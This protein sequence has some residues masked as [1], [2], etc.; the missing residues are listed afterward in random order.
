MA[1]VCVKA[2][3]A[4][5]V[6]MM[7]LLDMFPTFSLAI[8][9]LGFNKKARSFVEWCQLYYEFWQRKFVIGILKYVCTI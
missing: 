1:Q 8:S 2:D 6:Q 3:F 4:G 9:I 7:F 5:R